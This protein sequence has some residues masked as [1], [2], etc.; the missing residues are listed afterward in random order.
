MTV[1]PGQSYYYS[2]NLHNT[3]TGHDIYNLSLG[4]G[5][6]NYVIRNA[7]DNATLRAV[8]V[9]AGYSETVL[10]KVYGTRGFRK[11]PG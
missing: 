11:I 7:F 10:I 8:E 4:E 6:F 3:G 2:L 1:N 5:S 9:N